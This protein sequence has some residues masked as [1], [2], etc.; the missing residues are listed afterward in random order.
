MFPSS[1]R[2]TWILGMPFENI[3]YVPLVVLNVNHANRNALQEVK[4]KNQCFHI[5]LWIRE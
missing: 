3:S 2:L 1:T 4:K 5:S